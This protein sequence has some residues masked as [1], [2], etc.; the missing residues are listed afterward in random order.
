MKIFGKLMGV[1]L[2]VALLCGA[3]A[4]LYVI[5]P[6]RYTHSIRQ[7]SEEMG[8]DPYLVTALIKAESNFECDAKSSKDAKGLMQLT[9]ETA[10]FCAQKLGIEL[11]EGD[12]YDPKINIRLGSCYLKRTMD[13]FNQDDKM[14]IAA[15]NAGEGRVKEWLADKR[16]SAD[17]ET[18]DTIPYEETKKHVKKIEMYRKIYKILYPNL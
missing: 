2:T 4:L 7:C 12:V 18:L 1:I 10:A 8:L 15:Y 9:D 3:V 11:K 13:I 6:L 16:Y 5:Y 14:A 17:G